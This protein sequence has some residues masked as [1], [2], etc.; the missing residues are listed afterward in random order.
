MTVTG[1]VTYDQAARAMQTAHARMEELTNKNRDKRR[2]SPPDQAEF[3][4]LA[5]EFDDYDEHRQRIERAANMARGARTRVVPGSP[6]GDDYDRDPLR[7]PADSDTRFR[8]R[9]P[10]DLSEVRAWGRDPRETAAELHSRALSAIELMPG[11]SD[12]TRDSA[13]TILNQFDSADALIARHTLITSNPAYLRAWSKMATN[14]QHLLTD[15]EQ[16]A[17][18]EA[19]QFRA[20]SLTDSAGGFL[21]PFQMDPAIIVTSSGVL[22]EVASIAR[23]VVATG[24]VWHGVSSGAVQW[25]WDAEGTE[26]SDDSPTVA[27]PAVPIYKAQ[28][29]VPISVEAM[30]DAANITETVGVLFSEGQSDLEATAFTT[31]SGT[32]QPTG[33]ITA[34]TG[35]GSV[36]NSATAATFAQSDV[37]AVRDALPARWRRNASWL[38][39]NTIYSKVRQFDQY[40]GGGFWT[41]LNND[42]PPLLLGRNATESEAMATTTTTGSKIAVVGDFSNYVVARRLG[43]TVELIPHLFG[44]NRRPTG[45]RG[46]IAWY[47]VGADSVNDNAFRMLQIA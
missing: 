39:N 47:R 4:Q 3:D 7:D 38:A 40:G 5:D 23:Q 29:F 16:R 14:R 46:W 24:D 20:M 13:T 2:W 9:D 45:Q 8:G 21:V 36:V 15:V 17:L 19:E 34:L 26:V 31:G 25:S 11:A 44:A 18:A 41:N 12:T 33:I 32:G 27:Q 22:S 42:R 28:G 1:N 30:Q 37:Y 35:T 43:M 6:Q 10:W